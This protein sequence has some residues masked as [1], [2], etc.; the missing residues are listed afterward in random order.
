MSYTDKCCGVCDEYQECSGVLFSNRFV[1]SNVCKKCISEK[2]LF[3]INISKLTIEKDM[4]YRWR[5]DFKKPYTLFYSP[6]TYKAWRF[7]HYRHDL[8]E[9]EKFLGYRPQYVKNHPRLITILGENINHNGI[10]TSGGIYNR[11]K[12]K[13]RRTL[14]KLGVTGKIESL[15]K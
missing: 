7:N 12:R 13:L 5:K 8:Q 15:I 6:I 11:D 2:A 3:G 10:F 9:V 1:I 4:A 14:R